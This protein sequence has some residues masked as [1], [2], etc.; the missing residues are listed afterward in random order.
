MTLTPCREETIPMIDEIIHQPVVNIRGGWLD[1]WR[2]SVVLD[3]ESA[4]WS[5]EL[6]LMPNE[7][8]KEGIRSFNSTNSLFGI[9]I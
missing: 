1:G 6:D 2:M 8:H 4:N 7:S 3:Y 9:L 5:I